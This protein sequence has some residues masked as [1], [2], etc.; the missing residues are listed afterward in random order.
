MAT[1]PTDVLVLMD[2][3]AFTG[4]VLLSRTVE[5]IEGE[6]YDKKRRRR[7]DRIITVEKD[8]PSFAS[9]K[10]IADLGKEFANEPEEFFTNYHRMCGKNKVL[11]LTGPERARQLIRSTMIW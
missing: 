8:A 10:S 3:T 2:E 5:A 9:I 7:N 4:C 1:N 11:R 6:R